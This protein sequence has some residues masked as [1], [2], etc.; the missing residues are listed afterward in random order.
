MQNTEVTN[1]QYREFLTDLELQGRTGA[2]AKAGIQSEK[3]LQTGPQNAALATT[4]HKHAAYDDYPVVN[5]T[6]EGAELYCQWLG[7]TLTRLTK[8]N[9]LITARLPSKT[10][11]MYAAYGGKNAPYPWGGYYLRNSK[12]CE[13]AHFRQMGEEHITTDR[14]TGAA[15]FREST[16]HQHSRK[17][18]EIGHFTIP[19]ESYFPNSYGLYQ[20][21]GNVAEMLSEK[22]RF[23]GGSWASVGYDL[24]IDAES[25]YNGEVEASP[26]IGF[27]PVIS[28]TPVD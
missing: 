12:G 6:H 27:R 9:Y 14:Q 7:E 20:M 17:A 22:G 19:V 8:G 11:W 2:L 13:L 26:Y 18:A 24:R 10:E 4:Y 1:L 16:H 28:A 3:W 21:S 5:I 25:E 23:K 15:T